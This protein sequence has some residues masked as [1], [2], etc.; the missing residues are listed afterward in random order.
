MYE[1]EIMNIN[2]K[3]RNVITG[4]DFEEACKFWKLDSKEWKEMA[5]WY[6]D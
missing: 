5:K 3:E 4:F 1:I 2:T 6:I